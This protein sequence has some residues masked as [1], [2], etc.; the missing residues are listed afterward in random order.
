VIELGQQGIGRVEYERI[1]DGHEPVTI[2]SGVLERLAA[3]RSRML[4]HIGTGVPAYG[5]T[6]GLGHLARVRVSTDDQGDLQHSL[7]TARA[8]ATG[9]P[10][11]A[12]VVRGAMLVRLAGFLH[13]AAGVTPELCTFLADRL[14][15]GWSPLV[16]EGPYGASGEI[17][18]LAHLFQTLTGEG[19]VVVE[20]RRLDAAEALAAKGVAPYEPRTKEGLA[21]I[22]GSPFATALGIRLSGR[23]D[24][25][26]KAATTTAALSLALTRMGARAVSPSV[27]LL[28]RDGFVVVVQERLSALLAEEDVWGDRA[29]PPV[30]ARVIP[31]VHG[32]ALR[33]VAGL[34]TLLEARLLGTSDSPVFIASD[35][36]EEGLYPSGGFHAIEVV[37]ALEA[38]ANA[39]C[40]VL[41]LLEKRLHRLLDASFSGLPDQLTMRPGVQAGAVA[42][43]KTVVG[44][45]A[46]ARSLAAPSSVH[47]IDTSSGQED[48]Q[49]FTFLVA[50][51]AGALLDALETA[52]ACELVTLRQAAY[53]A[54]SRP[55]DGELSRVLAALESTIEP[56]EQDRSLAEDVARAG[57]LLRRGALAGRT[58][59]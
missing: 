7:L 27:G 48:V 36:D 17:G 2:A 52:L 29:Q 56:I 3:V 20:G 31:Q 53:V 47:A 45:T 44:L 14:N 16:P 15:D 46:E 49:S 38:V 58:A 33:F 25:L 41:N 6:T 10:L 55:S 21:L 22:N 8:A 42:L 9:T 1:V 54:A 26:I 5:V 59:G 35:G 11:P 40:H 57:E 4:A 24:D 50:A 30:S 43:H 51:R 23:A 13:G 18:A 28:Q 37:V 32:T 39:C 12:D 34:D 19:R